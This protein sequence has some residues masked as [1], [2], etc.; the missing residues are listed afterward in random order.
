MVFFVIYDTERSILGCRCYIQSDRNIRLKTFPLSKGAAA[1][2]GLILW[3][4]HFLLMDAGRRRINTYNE[5]GRRRRETKLRDG[6]YRMSLAM[7]LYRRI[8]QVLSVFARPDWIYIKARRRSH[9][10]NRLLDYSTKR[11]NVKC[12][13][14][15]SFPPGDAARCV[16]AGHHHPEA[17]SVFTSREEHGESLNNPIL[18]DARR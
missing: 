6:G 13:Y 1:T 5:E 18:T 7:P 8:R 11:N 15:I 9:L 12:H 4:K 3:N 10:V 2:L 14:V 17:S 16:P